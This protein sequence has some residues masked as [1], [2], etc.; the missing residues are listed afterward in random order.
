M[1]WGGVIEVVLPIVP[2]PKRHRETGFNSDIVFDESAE[3]FLQK[4]Q[5]AHTPLQNVSRRQA[6][7]VCGE[8]A[9]RVGAR[10]IRKIIV[11]SAADIGHVDPQVQCVLAA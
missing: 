3:H 8:A 1:L 7:L 5:M 6:G 4:G 2:H 11:A 9:K 10:R